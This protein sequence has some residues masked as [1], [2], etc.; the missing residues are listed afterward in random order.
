MPISHLARRSS[1]FQLSLDLSALDYVSLTFPALLRA[2]FSFVV[3]PTT[4]ILL[5]NP[6]VWLIYGVIQQVVDLCC[7]EI[8]SQIVI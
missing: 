8:N 3:Y 1:S 4:S 7:I 2:L 6:R 5:P